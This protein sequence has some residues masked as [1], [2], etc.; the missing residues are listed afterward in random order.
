MPK[1]LS[2]VSI[3][4]KTLLIRVIKKMQIKKCE[5]CSKELMNNDGYNDLILFCDQNCKN[6]FIE[7]HINDNIWEIIRNNIDTAREIV[8][9]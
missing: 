1:I 9:N 5:Y 8:L 7:D 3:S 4:Q 6:C 2:L